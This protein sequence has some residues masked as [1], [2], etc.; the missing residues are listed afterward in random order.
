MVQL[1]C[2][3]WPPAHCRTEGAPTLSPVTSSPTLTPRWLPAQLRHICG[4]WLRLVAPRLCVARC[5]ALPQRC[6]G[7][8]HSLLLTPCCVCHAAFLCVPPCGP[9]VEEPEELHIN[10]RVH[11]DKWAGRGVRVPH[12]LP[13]NAPTICRE[14]QHLR[15]WLSSLFS[16]LA[17]TL[18]WAF[19][20]C[21]STTRRCTSL[22][23][24]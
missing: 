4:R 24:G 15:A 2:A 11:R 13:G 17:A 21:T 16:R 7:F 9:D 1:F 19:C 22:T 10:R 12:V 14:S 3:H 5:C 18:K 6:Q 23:I 8:F 20:S